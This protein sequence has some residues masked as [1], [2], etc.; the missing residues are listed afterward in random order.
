MM[1]LNFKEQ[2]DM[3]VRKAWGAE[4][5][6]GGEWDQN[7]PSRNMCAV[8]AKVTRDYFPDAVIVRQSIT[9]P[10]Q[11]GANKSESHYYTIIDGQIYDPTREQYAVFPGGVSFGPHETSRG[12]FKDLYNYLCSNEDTLRRA[13]L[14]KSRVAV[15]LP[16]PECI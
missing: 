11:D 13:E 6:Y 9:I 5:T 16:R 1:Q 7:N 15:M 12:D 8:T 3:A 2:F 4:M 14:F 10:A